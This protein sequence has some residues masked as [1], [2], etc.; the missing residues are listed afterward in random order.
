MSTLTALTH[1]PDDLV[2]GTTWLVQRTLDEFK[3]SEGWTLEYQFSNA[4]GSLTSQTCTAVGDDFLLSVA[5]TVT[6]DFAVGTYYWQSIATS[7]D[8]VPLVSVAEH[9]KLNI[10]P[11]FTAA[12]D[13]RSHNQKM[14][15]AIKA[16]L[17]GKATSDAQEYNINTGTTQRHLKLLTWKELM[18]AKDR[19]T[20]LVATERRKADRARGIH[21]ST[22]IQAV[23]PD[24]PGL[25]G[26]QPWER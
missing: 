1:F 19:Y 6:A 17:E 22:N 14:L 24:R 3:A 26:R 23:F 21:R 20:G 11:Q 15:D 9:G 16:M 25:R 12:V 7:N 5:A 10:L 4:G 2:A 18:D 13:Y 8:S